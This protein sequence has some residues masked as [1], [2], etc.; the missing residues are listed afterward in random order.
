MLNT[1]RRW[2]SGVSGASWSGAAQWAQARGHAF[3]RSRDR[4][5]FVID[6]PSANPPW[7]LEW[8]PSQRPYIEGSE[9]R[10]RAEVGDAELQMVILSRQLM[11]AMEK[12]VFEEFTEDLQTRVDTATPEEMRW[13]VLFP[14]LTP[15]ELKILRDSFGAA[16]SAPM[17]VTQWLEGP[18]AAHLQ[19]ARSGWLAPEVPLALIL[20]R[21]RLT[22]RTAMAEPDAAQLSAVTSLFEVAAREA[23]RV[24]QSCSEHGLATT[25]PAAF[26]GG[27]ARQR[28]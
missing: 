6:A 3:K 23:R 4:E 28:R 8:G 16:G 21:G 27:E 17:W 2:F 18:L 1:I 15:A 14:K 26:D 12:S 7:R 13:L 5:G 10:L 11:D 19:Q 25:Q 22:L 20:Q 9:L 24:V